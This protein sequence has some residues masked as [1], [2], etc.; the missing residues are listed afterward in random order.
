MAQMSI[1]DA[2]GQRLASNVRRLRL[3]QGLSIRDV[4]TAAVVGMGSISRIEN[5]RVMPSVAIVA[6]LAVSFGVTVD[7]LLR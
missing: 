6:R 5:R 7:E 4:E 2:I 3:S 1:E